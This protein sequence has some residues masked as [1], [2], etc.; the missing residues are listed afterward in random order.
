MDVST[1]PIPFGGSSDRLDLLN[2][3]LYLGNLLD[4]AA[5]HGGCDIGTV[6]AGALD[7]PILHRVRAAPSAVRRLRSS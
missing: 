1:E 7:R 5:A 6:V 4:R 3:A 2:L